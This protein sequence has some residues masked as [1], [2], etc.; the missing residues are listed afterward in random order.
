MNM[1]PIDFVRKFSAMGYE[2]FTVDELVAAQSARLIGYH[3]PN[4]AYQLTE[5]G[6]SL[7][8][9]RPSPAFWQALS[10]PS[11]PP[12][13]EPSPTTAKDVQVGGDHYK[14]MGDYQ[15][16][17]VLAEWMTPEELRGHMKG[18]VIAYLAREK[19]KGGDQDIA[20]ALHTMQLFQE[21]R[22]DK[23]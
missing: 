5:L 12:L 23:S 13:P 15:P 18:T 11:C 2:P 21:L 3:G 8:E 1:S 7:L 22:K 20:K 19:Q 17:Q 16:W 6:V 9:T 14:T 4:G 10:A